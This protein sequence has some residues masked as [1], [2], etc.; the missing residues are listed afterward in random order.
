M[1]DQAVATYQV[2]FSWLHV[3]PDRRAYKPSNPLLIAKDILI[4]VEVPLTQEFIYNANSIMKM[5][6][7]NGAPPISTILTPRG[8][9][10]C[11]DKLE[12]EMLEKEVK[13]EKTTN[14][15]DEDWEKWS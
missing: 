9:R 10:Y 6:L 4:V 8:M 14:D 15:K 13:T 11:I 5:Q 1:A 7:D 12:E 3:Q 2:T